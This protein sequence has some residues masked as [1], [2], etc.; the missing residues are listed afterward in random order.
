MNEGGNFLSEVIRKGDPIG[1]LAGVLFFAG[2]LVC[3]AIWPILTGLYWRRAS[4]GGAIGAMLLGSGVG[5]TAYFEIGWYTASLIA[6]GV[7]FVVTML[8]AWLWPGD[9]SWKALQVEIGDGSEEE[10]RA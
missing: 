3:S 1:T 5:L 9:F 7:S 6:T 4:R 10:A 2:P 8:S